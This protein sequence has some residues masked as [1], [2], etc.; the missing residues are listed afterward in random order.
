MRLVA[1]VLARRRFATTSRIRHRDRGAGPFNGLE[2][3]VIVDRGRDS[4]FCLAV[5]RS[6]GRGAGGRD[7]PAS[8]S[9]A[10]RWR[11]LGE[12]VTV[13]AQPGPITL[14]TAGDD[15]ILGTRGPDVIHGVGRK[16]RICGL[17]GADRIVGGAGQDRLIGGPGED[18]VHGKNGDD[19]L[20]G[21]PGSDKLWG[22]TG[23]DRL[24]G[25]TRG[26]D[27]YLTGDGDTVF[28]Q[29]GFFDTVRY[30]GRDLH[31]TAGRARGSG[32]PCGSSDRTSGC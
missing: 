17:G 10:L 11:C 8:D 16:D 22:G 29:H 19:T 23:T 14:G 9:P 7:R 13:R 15:V 12:P 1:N 5:Q 20:L 21:G 31:P 26:D 25:G 18:F 2:S 30:R 24:C 27:Y 32:D 28:G 4:H 3:D 6:L